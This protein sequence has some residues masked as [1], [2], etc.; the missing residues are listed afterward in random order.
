M[1][2]GA[3]I[4]HRLARADLGGNRHA[5]GRAARMLDDD[6]CPRDALEGMKNDEAGS[7]GEKRGLGGN[8]RHGLEAAVA[9]SVER[10]F[11]CDPAVAVSVT[12]CV[13]DCEPLVRLLDVEI[14]DFRVGRAPAG[15]PNEK[16]NRPQDLDAI[17]ADPAQAAALQGCGQAAG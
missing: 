16:Q 6:L 17:P 10:D 8:L 15:R 7:I 13:A 12:S 11:G 2:Q 1:S 14:G 3:N 4:E 5:F 9:A